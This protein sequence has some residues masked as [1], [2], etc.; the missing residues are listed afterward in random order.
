MRVE[1]GDAWVAWAATIV[2]M[3]RAA[4][5]LLQE[6][7]ELGEAD[8]IDLAAELLATVNGPADADWEQAWGAELDRRTAEADRTGNAG[9]TWEEV[10]AHVLSRTRG[11]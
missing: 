3:T 10:R 8:R 5:K 1:R 9:D 2:E 7:L 11:V 4:A 6:A